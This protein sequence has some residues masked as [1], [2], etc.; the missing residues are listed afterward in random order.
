LEA[1]QKG[2]SARRFVTFRGTVFWRLVQELNLPGTGTELV[3]DA[4][5]G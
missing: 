5:R 4:R 3:A 1:G 2:G